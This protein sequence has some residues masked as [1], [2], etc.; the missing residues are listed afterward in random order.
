MAS[1][2]WTQ[3]AGYGLTLTAAGLT[4]ARY[5]W[6]RQSHVSGV[7]T[8][9]RTVS[10]PPTSKAS[11][12]DAAF[13][14]TGLTSWTVSTETGASADVTLD[15]AALWGADLPQSGWLGDLLSPAV[16]G[17]PVVVEHQRTILWQPRSTIYEIIGKQVPLIITAASTDTQFDMSLLLPGT[18]GQGTPSP[19]LRDL[20]ALLYS[21][22]ALV[23]R[24][25]CPDRVED[26]VFG[27]V[28]AT[29]DPLGVAGPDRRV[30]IRG[31]LVDPTPPTG[32]AAYATTW[33]AVKGRYGT[34]ADLVAANADW[35]ELLAQP[36][37]TLGL[38]S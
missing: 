8:P 20:R 26:V 22:R 34:W 3:E 15:P 36:P 27:V 7:L 2:T 25:M 24:S 9:L 10:S 17:V 4:G 32:S 28:D 6:R 19:A 13:P 23:L 38:P 30:A 18:P 33:S 12:F 21:G 5:T 29:E 11:F 37:A 31:R 16:A 14:L 35:D 1:I